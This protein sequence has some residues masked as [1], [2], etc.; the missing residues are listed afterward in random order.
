M[1]KKLYILVGVII[2]LL[3][4][5]IGLIFALRPSYTPSAEAQ[6]TLEPQVTLVPQ[7]DP[8]MQPAE[9]ASDPLAG[10]S[11]EEMGALAMA[12]EGGEE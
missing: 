3:C 7:D 6:Q 12:E 5:T 2:V 9:D 11:E 1:N 4:I 10:L 8:T